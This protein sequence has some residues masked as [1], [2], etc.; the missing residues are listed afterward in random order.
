MKPLYWAIAFPSRCT[1][2][3]SD[4]SPTLRLAGNGPSSVTILL[5][6]WLETR[7]LSSWAASALC[8]LF[9]FII[10]VFSANIEI[11]GLVEPTCGYG[12]QSTGYWSF[13]PE[14]RNFGRMNEPWYHIAA[15]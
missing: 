5:C 13:P 11:D 4:D 3:G 10:Q 6:A 1:I 8:W 15:F 14:P 9:L 2:G 12:N 7:K